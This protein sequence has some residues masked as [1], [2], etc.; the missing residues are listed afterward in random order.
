M[1]E[2]MAIFAPNI[3]VY[4]R[5]K[6]DQF[7]PVTRDRGENH[8]PVAFRLPIH[9]AESRPLEHRV[10]AAEANPYLVMA[11]ILAGVRYGLSDKFDS[12]GKHTGNVGA[13][14]D[15]DLPSTPWDVF[16]AV[17]KGQPC[18]LRLRP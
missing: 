8:R 10:A 2:A 13:E 6:P 14:V 7:V 18:A 1:A 11:S 5:F 17:V 16:R 15:P 4:R 3:N 9:D 12:G